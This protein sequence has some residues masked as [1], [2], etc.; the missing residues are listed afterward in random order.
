MC[1]HWLGRHDEAAPHFERARQLDPNGYYTTAH[2]GWHLVQLGDLAGA[3]PWFH[4]SLQ[5]KPID[6]P[7]AHSYLTIVERRLAEATNRPA[8]PR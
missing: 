7:I 2:Q 3:K 1:L 6:N 5:L 4:R 8:A